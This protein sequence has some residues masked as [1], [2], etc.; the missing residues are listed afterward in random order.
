M[1]LSWRNSSMA[2]MVIVW[3][4]VPAVRVRDARI[5]MICNEGTNGIQAMDLVGR[6]LYRNRGAYVARFAEQVRAELEG[7]DD[8]ERTRPFARP[9][10]RNWRAWSVSPSSCWPVRMTIP[11]SWG[12]QPAISSTWPWAGASTVIL[13]L[14]MAR[15]AV[16]GLATSGASGEDFYRRKLAMGN[17]F[18][19]RVL[20]RAVALEAQIAA[21]AAPLMAF[22]LEDFDP[23]Q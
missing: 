9:A 22:R 13:W 17:Y 8:D 19:L 23:A 12:R 7:Q 15:A 3:S 4:G 14:R 16:Q 5:A 20:P 11:R 1:P 18:V 21:S 2:A 6:K 10:S